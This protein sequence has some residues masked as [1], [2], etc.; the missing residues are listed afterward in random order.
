[1]DW[2]KLSA[3]LLVCLCFGSIHAY[4]VLLVP[5]ERWLGT[6]RTT[7]SFG[8]STAVAALTAGVYLSGRLETT[9]PPRRLLVACGSIAALGLLIAGG[10]S[11]VAGLLVGFGLMFGL[12]NGVAYAAS[13][14]LAAGAM[15]GRAAQ[16]MGL[17]TAAYGL[18][19]VL[20]AQ[21]FD[22]AVASMHVALVLMVVAPV[23]FVA[24]LL[25]AVLVPSDQQSVAP[26]AAEPRTTDHRSLICLWFSYLLGAFA[27]LLVLAH[28][29]AIAAWREGSSSQGGFV[30][31]AVSFGSVAG[32][33]LGGVTATWLPGPRGVALPLI[34]QATALASLPFMAGHS[35]IIAALGMAGLSYGVLIAVVPGEVRR[36]AGP[37]GFARSYGKVFSAWG[38][39]G[40]AGPVSA[41][42]LF[43]TTLGYGAALSAAVVLSLL[44]C[45][46][47]V[48]FGK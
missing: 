25:G 41:G 24:C 10:S 11:S 7:A 14:V 38:I 17:A 1:M 19:A 13:L 8:Y 18:G 6:G 36:I 22:A 39:A 16:A 40:V 35:T 32:G 44:S 4:G 26:E 5:I 23:V 46:V 45:L 47:I 20:C 3:A 12:A 48:G 34:V 9:L 42:Y 28:A 2:R 37:Q 30:S 31:G 27:G 43:D 15:P 29:P 33:W 21:V